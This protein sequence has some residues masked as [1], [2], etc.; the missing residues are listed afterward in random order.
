MASVC[1]PL[2]LCGMLTRPS[3]SS[4]IDGLEDGGGL[5]TYVVVENAAD[6]PTIGER[7]TRLLWARGHGYIKVSKA[8][9]PLERTIID[10]CVWQPERQD[11]VGPP[12]LVG[13][14][15][16]APEPF[17]RTGPML[18]LADVPDLTEE[19]EDNAAINLRNEKKAVAQEIEEA[20]EAWVASRVEQGM[21]EDEARQVLRSRVLSPNS[22]IEMVDGRKTT[23]AGILAEP[24]EYHEQQCFDPIEEDERGVAV[25]LSL[26]GEG[27]FPLMIISYKNG[28]TVYHLQPRKKVAKSGASEKS[29]THSKGWE[30]VPGKGF[31]PEKRRKARFSPSSSVPN[32][33]HKVQLQFR[34]A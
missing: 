34:R 22:P 12:E 21:T 24:H 23:V 3:T 13:V 5:H 30:V 7:L 10:D 18:T 28:K 15:R 27:N 11:Y 2:A 29:P 25:V 17:L 31:S 9:T 16:N 1:P 6:I 19:D 32:C 14:E 4:G 8:G 33:A 20:I 26:P